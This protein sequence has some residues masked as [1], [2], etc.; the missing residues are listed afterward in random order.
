LIAES[1]LNIRVWAREALGVQAGT[2]AQALSL[3][4]LIIPL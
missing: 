2:V 3:T 1:R 4:V